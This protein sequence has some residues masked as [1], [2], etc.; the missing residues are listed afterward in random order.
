MACWCP[1]DHNR[2]VRT[3]LSC[4]PSV[5]LAYGCNF[6]YLDVYMRLLDR[7]V[8]LLPCVSFLV[9]CPCSLGRQVLPSF[10]LSG[11]HATLGLPGCVLKEALLS[12]PFSSASS[13]SL[14]SL[15]EEV[16]PLPYPHLFGG[17]PNTNYTANCAAI[18]S[19]LTAAGA[20][21]F[22]SPPEEPCSPATTPIPVSSLR[23]AMAA[24]AQARGVLPSPLSL[25]VL[26]PLP[27]GSSL[28]FPRYTRA[29]SYESEPHH[30]SP[31][32]RTRAELSP[33]KPTPGSKF[34]CFP[35]SRVV[36]WACVNHPS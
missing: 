11:P 4:Q 34:R 29:D 24:L 3:H 8:R 13:P 17:H 2:P 36:L 10:T 21:Y 26:A 16:P 35:A 14:S 18:G 30:G 32:G 23:S 25:G 12:P 15:L 27:A 19:L 33:S 5:L 9:V 31:S 22:P 28:F 20:L 7:T 1:P 6:H